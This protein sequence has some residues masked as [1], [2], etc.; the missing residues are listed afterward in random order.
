MAQKASGIK[1]MRKGIAYILD[2][3]KVMILFLIQ[4]TYGAFVAYLLIDF[5]RFSLNYKETFIGFLIIRM[6]AMRND[7]KTIDEDTLF[8]IVF[9]TI[10]LIIWAVLKVIW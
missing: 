7:D 5:T 10:C 8:Y 3:I 6:L 1:T 2:I 4:V 9:T